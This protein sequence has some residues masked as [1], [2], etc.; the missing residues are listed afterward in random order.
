MK[1]ALI[2]IALFLASCGDGYKEIH[3]LNGFWQ[4]E[5]REITYLL[6]NGFARIDII[7]AGQVVDRKEYTYETERNTIRFTQY[8]TGQAA[9]FV[10]W[11][12]D[13]NTVQFRQPGGLVFWLVKK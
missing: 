9:Q 10:Y 4:R 11:F 2:L 12:Y 3:D 8:P 6:D 7:A 13:E 1:Q 5:D